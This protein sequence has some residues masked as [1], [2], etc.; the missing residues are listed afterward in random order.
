V[1]FKYITN[2]INVFQSISVGAS[3]SF[4]GFMWS[5][6]ATKMGYIWVIR[7]GEKVCFWKDNWLGLLV[8]P[9]NT[10]D[11]IGWLMKKIDL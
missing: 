3:S 8:W 1:D 5:I 7:N 9:F 6:Q 10:G 11:Y 2:N 4:Q